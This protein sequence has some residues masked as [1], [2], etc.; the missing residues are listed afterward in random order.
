[1]KNKFYK[2]AITICSLSLALAPFLQF[3]GASVLFFGEPENP[4]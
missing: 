2:A 1:M 4:M 3:K